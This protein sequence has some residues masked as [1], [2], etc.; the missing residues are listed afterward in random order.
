MKR[1]IVALV[2]LSSILVFAMCAFGN[3]YEIGFV[4]MHYNNPFM[5]I[6][7]DAAIA[8]AQELGCT[9]TPIDGQAD[10]AVQIS[11][12]ENL[13]SKGVDAIILNAVDAVAL[14]PVVEQATQ[15]GIPVICVDS[16]VNTDV[17][18]STIHTDNVMAGVYAAGYIVERLNG[19]G[20][21]AMLNY[22]PVSSCAERESGLRAVLDL[23]PGITIVAEELAGVPPGPIDTAKNML[24]ANPEIDAFF[25]INDPN[26]LCI[27][28]AI[29]EMGMAESVFAVG[30]D[31]A[32]EAIDAM[33]AGKPFG[34]TSAQQPALM[35]EMAVE[36]VV[37][38]LN[39]EEVPEV[40][41]IPVTLIRQ[42]DLVG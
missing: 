38:Y 29:E 30:V 27:A 36:Y 10:A 6:M 14:I 19:E 22:P 33:K 13:I 25:G 1:A 34:A 18:V 7:K 2:T 3:G 15:A 23:Y 17:L 37:A 42:E 21:V 4:L 5:V 12:M 8:R 20:Q 39:G 32:A 41:R 11:A 16:T 9:I 26:A 31:G 28:T 24:T 40:V 35:A